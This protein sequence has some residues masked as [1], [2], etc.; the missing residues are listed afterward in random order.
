MKSLD[1]I[2]QKSNCTVRMCESRF[3]NDVF[4]GIRV[5][6][7]SSDSALISARCE[8]LEHLSSIIGP[9]V[10]EI[11]S[12]M[13]FAS[14]RRVRSFQQMLQEIPRWN[15]AQFEEHTRAI[16]A[17]A[18]YV[19]KLIAA[20]LI[21]TVKLLASIKVHDGEENVRLKLP[22]N[23]AFISKVFIKTARIFY[24]SPD[25]V[26]ESANQKLQAV[27]IAVEKAVRDM[28]PLADLLDSYTAS[29]GGVEKVTET[30]AE[31]EDEAEAVE[32]VKA[33]IDAEAEAV[34][35]EESSLDREDDGA[36]V[37]EGEGTTKRISFE[38]HGGGFS[39]P[40]QD[41]SPPVPMHAYGAP[42]APPATSPYLPQQAPPQ[43]HYGAIPPAPPA[44]LM[45]GVQPLR[46]D[47][48]ETIDW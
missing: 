29:G 28:L 24:E 25:L 17:R 27:Q 40:P 37:E 35:E 20:V 13:W 34:V 31:T 1:V 26:R 3:F 18:R 9:Y 12:G 47:A 5:K 33:E 39:H 48:Q 43:P 38:D 15:V 6:M 23:E 4:F 14:K 44:P 2:W 46:A 21:A 8:Y 30:L 36:E 11:I 32:E 22:T 19:D 42:P 7:S 10:L 41:V 45:Q 16:E